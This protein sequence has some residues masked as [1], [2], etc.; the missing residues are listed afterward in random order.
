MDGVKIDKGNR[1]LWQRHIS[2]VPQNITLFD[3]SIRENVAFGINLNKIDDEKIVSSI[4]GAQ[5]FNLVE[6]WENKYQ[7][8]VGEHGVRISGGQRQRIGLARAL[9]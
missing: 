2:S 9:Y 6:S 4:N 3:N 7:T 8:I 1:H 5:L